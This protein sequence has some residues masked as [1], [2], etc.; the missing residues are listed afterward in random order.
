VSCV[1]LEFHKVVFDI[2]TNK[3]LLAL[4]YTD[5]KNLV[6]VGGVAANFFLCSRISYVLRGH[7]V[8]VFS[9]LIK[10]CTDNAA[11]IALA[12]YMKIAQHKD[13]DLNYNINSSSSLCLSRI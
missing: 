13:I 5:V 7:N 1:S 8:S 10:Y 6:I 12:G 11:M 3:I 4:K 2:I 9:P